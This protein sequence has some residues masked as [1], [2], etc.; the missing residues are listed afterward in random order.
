M[1]ETK[2]MISDAAQKV[3]VETH[4]LR[5]W[6]EELE[7]PIPRTELGHRYYTEKDIHI[8][9]KIKELKDRGL[10]LKAIKILLPELRKREE[11][12]QEHIIDLEEKKS[13]RAAV[14]ASPD[15][16]LDKLV[17]LEQVF[18]AAF[19]QILKENNMV[20]EQQLSDSIVQEM[21]L[22]MKLKEEREEERFHKLDE[23]IRA[24]Q[25]NFSMTAATKEKKRPF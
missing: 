12:S 15:P 24:H 17:R 10:Q 23:T 14:I 6:E 22:L 19:T 13:Q 18:R 20:L 3:Q 25:K 5:Y 9:Q 16:D 2:Y 8:F 21:N 4:V 11:E 7:L 1:A